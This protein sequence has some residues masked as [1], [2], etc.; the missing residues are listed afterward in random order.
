[1]KIYWT[2]Y[3]KKKMA[4]ETSEIYFD[5]EAA[6]NVLE[7]MESVD[8]KCYLSDRAINR[9]K[10]DALFVMRKAIRSLA[11]SWENE[12]DEDED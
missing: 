3:S 12:K 6:R 8:A 2:P 5:I 1:M 4:E 11:E 9:M 10:K 7:S